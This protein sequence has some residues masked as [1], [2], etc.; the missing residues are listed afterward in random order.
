MKKDVIGYII[1]AFILVAFM[2]SGC[3]SSTTDPFEMDSMYC[4]TYKE[5]CVDNEPYCGLDFDGNKCECE[6]DLVGHPYAVRECK[7]YKY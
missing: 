4:E 2:F 7:V 6:F 3:N 5:Y 1:L